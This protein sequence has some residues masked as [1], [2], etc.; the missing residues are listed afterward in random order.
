VSRSHP[1]VEAF[2]TWLVFAAGAAIVFYTV[3]PAF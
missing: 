1:I 2:L 3:I